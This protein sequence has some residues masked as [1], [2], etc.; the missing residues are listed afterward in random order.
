MR[1]SALKQWEQKT[2][3]S[4]VNWDSLFIAYR[5]AYRSTILD[6]WFTTSD[7]PVNPF[8]LTGNDSLSARCNMSSYLLL[9][10][11][12]ITPPMSEVDLPSLCLNLLNYFR[13]KSP[14]DLLN[15]VSHMRP[16]ACPLFREVTGATGPSL[17]SIINS[18]FFLKSGEWIVNECTPS[19]LYLQGPSQ[20]ERALWAGYH[21]D[22]CPLVQCTVQELSAAHSPWCTEWKATK[23]VQE[24]LEKKTKWQKDEGEL[25]LVI[26]F[27]IYI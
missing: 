7:H 9:N 12:N 11:P 18:Y 1:Y 26:S 21:H 27:N 25:D 3:G 16:S 13:S 23:W 8:S 6:I 10:A 24:Q 5:F 22:F 15:N 17:S 14:H 2:S 19:V 4:A 20:A